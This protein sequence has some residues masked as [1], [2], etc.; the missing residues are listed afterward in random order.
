MITGSKGQFTKNTEILQVC[1]ELSF[2][3]QAAK[4]YQTE[5]RIDFGACSVACR[6]VCPHP[7]SGS[8]LSLL[9]WGNLPS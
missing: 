7:W 3:I 2:K 9:S 5:R 6:L 8:Q 4:G 1:A